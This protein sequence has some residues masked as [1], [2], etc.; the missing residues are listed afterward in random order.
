[1]VP[2]HLTPWSPDGLGDHAVAV[3]TA[4][5]ASRVSGAVD[6]G[7]DGEALRHWI[8]CVDERQKLRAATLRAPLVKGSHEQLM[9]NPLFRRT[10]DLGRDI[11]RAEEHFGMTPLARLRLGVTFLQ[12]QAAKEDL[13]A[14]RANRRPHAM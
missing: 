13:Q 5:W 4:F 9:L 1:M 12:E 14:R 3:W 10:R 2:A 11:A 7:A 8:L 6:L